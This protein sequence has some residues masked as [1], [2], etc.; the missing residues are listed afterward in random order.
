M[1]QSALM[2]ING[3]RFAFSQLG[4]PPAFSYYFGEKCSCRQ[5]LLLLG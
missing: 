2:K 5:A 3:G 4:T 1:A